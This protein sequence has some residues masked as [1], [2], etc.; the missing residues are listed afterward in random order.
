M[1][2]ID[3]FL[4]EKCASGLGQQVRHAAGYAAATAG[5]TAAGAYGM[6]AVQSAYHAITKK[7]DFQSMLE[8]NPDLK[9]HPNPKLVLQGFTSL[10]TFAPKFSQDPL[11]AGSY[12]RRIAEN[13]VGMSGI[14]NEA[15]GAHGAM[16][17]AFEATQQAV[18]A[19]AL[20]G[21]DLGQRGALDT[22][23]K[24]HELA[25]AADQ[26]QNQLHIMEQQH[27]HQQGL[28]G[29]QAKN[30]QV[31]TGV[32]HALQQQRDQAGRTH[33]FDLEQYRANLRQR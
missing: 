21:L 9:D 8:E 18:G 13:P 20:K 22:Q 26:H 3:D 31:L 16:P 7:R 5:V 1:S 30:Q 12:V 23:R 2:A 14:V 29:T 19:G 25:M 28:A 27:A 24:S 6:Q 15:M 4:N 11:V 17:S 33:D 10:R 32:Q